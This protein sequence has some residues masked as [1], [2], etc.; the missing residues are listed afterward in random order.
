MLRSSLAK[1]VIGATLLLELVDEVL[2]GAVPVFSCVDGGH[3]CGLPV[4]FNSIGHGRL[5]PNSDFVPNCSCI[6]IDDVLRDEW[7]SGGMF[8][9]L[10]D[11]KKHPERLLLV[12]IL[13]VLRWNAILVE[14]L[15]ESMSLGDGF[16]LFDESIHVSTFGQCRVIR[17]GRFSDFLSFLKILP[18]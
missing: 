5:D 12:Q 13:L 11:R 4:G 8:D 9:L 16:P 10:V 6:H 15:R 17:V 1:V 7:T 14:C 18:S 2:L 3:P